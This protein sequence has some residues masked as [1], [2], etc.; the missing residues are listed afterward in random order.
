MY[1]E[2]ETLIW[3]LKPRADMNPADLIG[4]KWMLMEIDGVALGE[5]FLV[6]TL[7][8]IEDGKVE[9]AGGCRPYEATYVAEGDKLT[10]TSLAMLAD[11]CESGD[12]LEFEQ[13]FTT[14][15]S[16]STNYV[17]DGDILTIHSNG[18]HVMRFE[19]T[20]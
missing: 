10:F 7:N 16:T 3:T 19:R 9:G 14:L 6:P 13:N 11:T 4:S 18:G 8:F 1:G 15:L 5:G 2:A 20:E 17:I 12:D